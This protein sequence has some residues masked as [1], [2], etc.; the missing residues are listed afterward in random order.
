MHRNNYGGKRS[1]EYEISLVGELL[2]E[3][4]C[5]RD[6]PNL[7]HRSKVVGQKTERILYARR[8]DHSARSG[9]REAV[10]EVATCELVTSL[11]LSTIGD[12]GTGVCSDDR[13]TLSKKVWNGLHIIITPVI[14]YRLQ[15][16]TEKPALEAND[17]K[18]HTFVRVKMRAVDKSSIFH[19]LNPS[20][21]SSIINPSPF[22]SLNFCKIWFQGQ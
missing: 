20:S 2:A 15:D 22:P 12:V 1:Q 10:R 21:S 8:R 4:L 19:R 7:Y 5:L 17:Y 3:S 14:Q 16:T 13:R 18:K 11:F 9:S 6:Q